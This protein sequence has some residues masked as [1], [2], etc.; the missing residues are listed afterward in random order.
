[1]NKTQYFP[2]LRYNW[3]S[4]DPKAAACAQMLCSERSATNNPLRN[5]GLDLSG[6]FNVLLTSLEVCMGYSPNSSIHIAK[7]KNIYT[8]KQRRSASYTREVW[9]ALDFLIEQQYLLL[10]T[11]ITKTKDKDG[12]AQWRP[13]R[14][15]LSEK[16]L[17][18]ISDKPLSDP[19]L[20]RRNPSVSNHLKTD[21]RGRKPSQMNSALQEMKPLHELLAGEIR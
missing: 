8:G 19:K 5:R 18:V 12:I 4:D 16:W 6:A 21:T 2:Y 14:Y 10:F 11:G 3:I 15:K 13:A 20:I 7:D 9:S 1:M 17:S